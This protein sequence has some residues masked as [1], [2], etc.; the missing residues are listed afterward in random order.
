MT[1]GPIATDSSIVTFL[2]PQIWFRVEI[3]TQKV[4]NR[5]ILV[6]IVTNRHEDFIPIAQQSSAIDV[7]LITFVWDK[8]LLKT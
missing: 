2:N 3:G 8:K 5:L 7:N 1:A 6:K 4:I